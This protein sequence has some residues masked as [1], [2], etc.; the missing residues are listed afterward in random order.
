VLYDLDLLRLLFSSLCFH[1]ASL[2]VPIPDSW[3][4]SVIPCS[5]VPSFP[6]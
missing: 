6:A 1:D 2:F 3:R 5:L 4:Y